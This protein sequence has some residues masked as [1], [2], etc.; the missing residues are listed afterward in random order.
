ME[1]NIV[2]GNT[3]ILHEL[4]GTRYITPYVTTFI[5]SIFNKCKEEYDINKVKVTIDIKYCKFNYS[6]HAE[7]T[8]Y[9]DTINFIDSDNTFVDS[10][11]DHNSR[12]SSVRSL[13]KSGKILIETIP[14]EY[15]IVEI[16]KYIENMDKS[17]VYRLSSPSELGNRLPNISILIAM[18]IGCLYPEVS[19]D[20]SEQATNYFSMFKKF[21]VYNEIVERESYNL[22][23]QG[24]ILKID[25]ISKDENGDNIFYIPGVGELTEKIVNGSFQVIPYDFGNKDI[26]EDPQLHNILEAI[27]TD[28]M[29]SMRKRNKKKL[30]SEL[31]TIVNNY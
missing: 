15:D 21:W 11:L 6:N 25:A 1:Y 5:K 17:K 19:I 30:T 20:L 18:A 14:I 10:M 3:Y 22:L 12:V 7:V 28:L 4:L 23:W 9:A 16:L 13:E 27:G 29:I 24:N 31:K 26:K 8:K 2:S